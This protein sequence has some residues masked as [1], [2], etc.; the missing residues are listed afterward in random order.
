MA[1]PIEYVDKQWKDWSEKNPPSTFKHIDKEQLVKVLTEDLNYA[2]QMD[3][4]EYTLKIFCRRSIYTF[5]SR[6]SNGE[7][8]TRKTY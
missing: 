6:I 3:V 2:S 8:G 1:T 7:S 4:R 5:W